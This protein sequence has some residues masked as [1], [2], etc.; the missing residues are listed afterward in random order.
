MSLKGLGLAEM[1]IRHHQNA[2]LLPP[3]CALGQKSKRFLFPSPEEWITH[4]ETTC[5]PSI[6]IVPGFGL[7]IQCWDR[8]ES[9][10]APW[11]FVDVG[12]ILSKFNGDLADMTIALLIALAGSLGAMAL[13]V[14][15]LEQG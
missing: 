1:Q 6:E 15:K 12:A 3:Q 9:G 11:I 13:I 10:V 8:F 5:K 4:S 7:V 2:A 14:K